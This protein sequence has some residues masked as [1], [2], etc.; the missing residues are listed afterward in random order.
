MEVVAVT[1]PHSTHTINIQ[2]AAASISSL[3]GRRWE[4]R[5]AAVRFLCYRRPLA[6]SRHAKP[7]LGQLTGDTLLA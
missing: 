4:M 1:N 6:S 5:S 2:P 7:V 3:C